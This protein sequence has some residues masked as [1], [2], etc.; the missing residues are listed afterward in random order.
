MA[1]KGK[2]E[3]LKKLLQKKVVKIIPIWLLLITVGIGTTFAAVNWI[4]NQITSTTIVTA[5]PIVITG[6]FASEQLA[7]ISTTQ[8][9]TYT[10]SS[11]TPTGY[12]FMRFT[13][14]FDSVSDCQVSVKI[15]QPDNGEFVDGVLVGTPNYNADSS[16]ISFMFGSS[17]S[18]PFS[19]GSSTG[20]IAVTTTYNNLGSVS[21]SLQVTSSAS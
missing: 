20:Q 5:L 1:N 10:I 7:Q 15:W 8:T 17:A 12:I 19:F 16:V 9:F 11:G 21:G 14:Q 3:K 2:G 4:S 6:S 18:Q 13:G